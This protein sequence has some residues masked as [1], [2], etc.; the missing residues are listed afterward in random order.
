VE[1]CGIK[2]YTGSKDDVACESS[3]NVSWREHLFFEP[4]QVHAS[5]IELD[6]ISIRVKNKGIFKDELIGM[7][8]FD[9]TKV[10]FEKQHAIQNQWIALFNPEGENFSEV[11]GNLKV[12]IS[13]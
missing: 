8:E 2:K 1:T 3:T 5:E 12:S 6:T 13:I 11:S 7:Y 9:I 10:Y 4:R